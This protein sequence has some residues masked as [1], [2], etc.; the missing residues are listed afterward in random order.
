MTFHRLL[1]QSPSQ[2]YISNEACWR[3][4]LS[5]RLHLVHAHML[6]SDPPIPLFRPLH[7]PNSCAIVQDFIL[8]FHNTNGGSASLIKP[9]LFCSLILQ[10]SKVTEAHCSVRNNSIRPGTGLSDL[11]WYLH[12]PSPW[13]RSETHSF[14]VLCCDHGSEEFGSSLY[15]LFSIIH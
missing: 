5:C 12:D 1:H 15:Q 3:P 9:W 2:S 8:L 6:F 14:T 13:S 11:A 7:S 4:R 10:N